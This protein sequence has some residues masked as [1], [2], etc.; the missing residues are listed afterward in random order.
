MKIA[1]IAMICAI[2]VREKRRHR[3]FDR[4]VCIGCGGSL[5]RRQQF[6]CR[7]ISKDSSWLLLSQTGNR[8]GGAISSA[9]LFSEIEQ[10]KSNVTLKF[11]ILLQSQ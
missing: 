9:P 3:R 4:T 11:Q 5:F 10:W 7:M 2:E 6:S 8:P 1:K